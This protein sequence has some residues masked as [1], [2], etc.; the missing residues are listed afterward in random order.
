MLRHKDPRYTLP[1][2]PALAVLA[3]SWL[4][5]L[6]ARARAWGAGIF[7]A[8]GALAFLTISFGTSLLPTSVGLDVPSTRFNPSRLTVFAQTGYLTG[9][10]SHEHWHQEEP[11]LTMSRFPRSQRTFAYHG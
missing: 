6:S 5:Y 10:P 4:E 7:V 1:M 11:F 9:A 8:Y 3:T 2:L